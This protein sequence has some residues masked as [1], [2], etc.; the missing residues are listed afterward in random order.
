[1]GDSTVRQAEPIEA[2]AKAATEYSRRLYDDVLAWYHNADAKAQV[3][4]GLDTAFLA[5]VTTGAFQK[6]EDV[7]KLTTRVPLPTW[8]LLGLMAITLAVSIGAAIYCLWSRI[9]SSPSAVIESIR[10]K[11]GARTAGTYPPGVMWFF[12][13]LAALDPGMFLRTLA[14]VDSAFEVDALASQITILASNVRRKHFAVNVGFVS[15]IATVVLFAGSALFYVAAASA[16][17]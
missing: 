2:A 4:L 14:S 13:F 6:P 11:G 7:V 12:Q 9:Y 3:V 16:V 8:L 10:A 1:M 5:F 15:A 17:R